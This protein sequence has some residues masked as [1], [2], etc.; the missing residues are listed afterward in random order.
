MQVDTKGLPIRLRNI[1]Y[2]FFAKC[3]VNPLRP[4]MG[5]IIYP[6]QSVFVPGILITDNSLLALD[7]IHHKKITKRSRE[8]FL[9]IEVGSIN[10]L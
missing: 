9:C 3:P 4:L 10:V 5:E 1:V 2:I 7:F 8:K 6:E